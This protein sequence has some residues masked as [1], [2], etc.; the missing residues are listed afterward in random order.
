MS[1]LTIELIFLLFAAW[2]A[3][4]WG[5]EIGRLA[6]VTGVLCYLSGLFQASGVVQQAG[7]VSLSLV[8]G[9]FKL[10]L[11]PVMYGLLIYAASLII[12]MIQK[13]RI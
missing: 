8:A 4:A 2:K 12:R 13:P 3:P 5:R 7:D 11:I 6:L 1:V 10:S 9:G